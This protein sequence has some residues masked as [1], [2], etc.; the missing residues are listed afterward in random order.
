[1]SCPS[2]PLDNLQSLWRNGW[3]LSTKSCKKLFPL[4][5]LCQTKRLTTWSLKT[6]HKNA[7]QKK[8]F[9]MNCRG[10]SKRHLIC[11][12]KLLSAHHGGAGCRCYGATCLTWNRSIGH[13]MTLYNTWM[14]A[15]RDTEGV[16]KVRWKN[17]F[18][19]FPPIWSE[20]LDSRSCSDE[21]AGDKC[22]KHSKEPPWQSKYNCRLTWVLSH[23][24]K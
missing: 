1:M 24:F 15:L 7:I 6:I 3:V 14:C 12:G 2:C 4:P 17:A 18:V 23:V 19:H 10:Q 11:R 20:R 22:G 5:T 16:K 21:D 9:T 13:C 8:T